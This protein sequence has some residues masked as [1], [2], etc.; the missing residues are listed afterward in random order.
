MRRKRSQPPGISV[1]A[2]MRDSDSRNRGAA[3]ELRAKG[4]EV[5]ELDVTKDV[6]VDAAFKNAVQKTDGKLDVLINNAGLF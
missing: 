4:I 1:F 6:S 2:T 3:E 5:V